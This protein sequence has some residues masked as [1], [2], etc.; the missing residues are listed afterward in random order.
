MSRYHLV[1]SFQ[2]E[3]RK[4]FIVVHTADKEFN[5]NIELNEHVRLWLSAYHSEYCHHLKFEVTENNE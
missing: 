2:E 3:Q 1:A 5:D 4:G